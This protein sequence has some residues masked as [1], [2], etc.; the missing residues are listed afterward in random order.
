MADGGA[1]EQRKDER[2]DIVPVAPDIHVD[3]VQ[4]EEEREAPG[5]T[6]D[7]RLLALREELVD[8]VAEQEE[9]D[10]RPD[11]ECVWCPVGIDMT[12]SVAN[13]SG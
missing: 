3:R 1:H 5:D 12:T 2:D 13:F 4:D 9:V 7:D 6:V 8:D 11:V 10:N